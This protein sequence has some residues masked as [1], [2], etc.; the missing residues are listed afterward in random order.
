MI[1]LELL[2]SN[3]FVFTKHTTMQNAVFKLESVLKKCYLSVAKAQNREK[4]MHFQTDLDQCR[5]NISVS[6]AYHKYPQRKKMLKVSPDLF[7]ISKHF[8][9]PNGRSKGVL[10]QSGCVIT[11]GKCLDIAFLQF[12]QQSI[13]LAM[14]DH[15]F[16]SQM[17]EFISRNT[18]NAM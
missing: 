7:D 2:F 1:K 18:L 10:W 3:T 17:H 9:Y 8:A 12:K 4:K 11:Q 5:C 13:A 6:L 14:Q 15:G 16:N